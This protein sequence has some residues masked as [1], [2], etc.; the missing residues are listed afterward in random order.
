MKY[1]QVAVCLL[2]VGC[3]GIK[4]QSESD[5]TLPLIDESQV[6]QSNLSDFFDGYRFVFLETN[7]ESL[8]GTS[9]SK[10]IVLDHYLFVMDRTPIGE[11]RVMSFHKQ[12]GSFLGQ[13]GKPGPG[14]NEYTTLVDFTVDRENKTVLLYSGDDK[15]MLTFTLDGSFVDAKKASDLFFLISTAI[16]DSMYVVANA[17]LTN[18][19]YYLLKVKRSDL[20]IVNQQLRGQDEYS[21]PSMLSS[22][23]GRFLLWVPADTIYDVTDVGSVPTYAIRVPEGERVERKKALR[24]PTYDLKIKKRSEL[25]NAGV[26]STRMFFFEGAN[27]LSYTKITRM[28]KGMPVHQ[29]FYLFDKRDNRLYKSDNMMYDLFG[30]YRLPFLLYT[31]YENEYIGLINPIRFLDAGKKEFLDKVTMTEEDRL[32]FTKLDEMANPI[33]LFLKEN[34]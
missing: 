27:H 8:L 26:I 3:N 13:I 10:I 24:Q 5:I 31:V 32:R 21:D 19:G 34:K 23:E 4:D 20:S 17:S 30:G 33:V 28:D 6:R 29:S 1:L 18:P 25:F 22:Y 11:R 16:Q 2:I 14:P 12:T 15:R 7:S 9:I